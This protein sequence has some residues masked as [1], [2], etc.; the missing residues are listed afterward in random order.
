MDFSI[1]QQK[2]IDIRDTNVVVSASA[3]SGKTAVLVERLC[4]LVLKD[5]ISIDSILAMTFTKDAAAEMKA[6]LLSKLKE[7]PKTEYILQQMALLETASIST[8][9]SFCLSI[10]QNYYYKIPI[11]Y[12]M[13]KQT[14]SSAQTRITFDNAYKHA[15]QDLD[16]DAY[17]KLKMYFLSFGKTEEDIQKYIEDILAILNS[18]S[19]EDAKTWIKNIQDSYTYLSPELMEYALKYFH[20]HCLA[21]S[22]SSENLRKYTSIS[23]YYEQKYLEL[24]SIARYI[25]KRKKK[26]IF[27][28]L[29]LEQTK[30]FWEQMERSIQILNEITPSRRGWC[31]GAYN[32]HNII[33]TS[34]APATIHFEHFYH[35]YPILDVYYFLKKALEKNNYNFAFCE[36]FLSNYDRFM[37][38]SKDDL[39]CLYGLF[40]FPE[41]FWKITNSYYHSGKAWIP[42]KNVEKLSLSVA[43]TEEKKRFLRNLFAFQI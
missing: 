19:E 27:E 28:Y 14:A 3:G 24:K 29:F 16:L 11:S 41:K 33:M 18:K 35:G 9:D 17:T 37:P 42:A 40:L 36:T 38:L 2:A 20:N 25:R 23:T 30:A 43:Q 4:Q 12:T 5:H 10:V 39:L 26:G 1:P 15:V 8:I 6:R 13:S 31:H 34:S 22:F 21:I 7:Q 32:H